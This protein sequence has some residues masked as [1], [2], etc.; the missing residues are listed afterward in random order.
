MNV[1]CSQEALDDLLSTF[2]FND[3]VLRNLV[4]KRDEAVTEPSVLAKSA[5]DRRMQ[6]YDAAYPGYGFAAHK[7]YPTRAHRAALSALGPCPEHR[8]S[9]APVRIAAGARA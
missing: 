2:R 5:R 3:A 8:R 4:I 9:F 6:E 7:G 1:E